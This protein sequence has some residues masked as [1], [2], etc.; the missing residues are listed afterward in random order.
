M[1]WQDIYMAQVAG[2]FFVYAQI[3]FCSVSVG[4]VNGT[5]S[6]PSRNNHILLE[7][8][9]FFYFNSLLMIPIIILVEEPRPW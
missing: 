3:A 2:T 8:P 1:Y 5:D 7:T 9:L 4:C 6:L